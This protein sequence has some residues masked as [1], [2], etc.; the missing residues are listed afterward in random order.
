VRY[1]ED[2]GPGIAGLALLPVHVEPHVELLHVLDLVF[3]DEPRPERAERLAALALGPL[4]AALGLEV[5]LRD[6]VAD[7]VAGDD[8]ERVL[9]RQIARAAPDHDRDLAFVVE[10]GRGLR[11]HG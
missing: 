10:L 6:V 3:G 11:D 9:L 7:A 5:A 1:A 2:H 8:I 4:S